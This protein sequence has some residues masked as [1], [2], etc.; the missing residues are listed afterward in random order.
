[1]MQDA[2]RN[3]FPQLA[4]VGITH[5]WSGTMAW[6]GHK[7]PV[8]DQLN[9]GVWILN[10][11]GGHGLNTTALAGKL[12]ADAILAG[13]TDWQG[14]EDYTEGIALSGWM[15]R[16]AAYGIYRS[17]KMKDWWSERRAV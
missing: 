15:G 8:I 4:D 7:M 11:F 3:D 1:M 6:V 9:P 2:I 10:G 13:S 5:A 12:V 16:L 14:F 17:Y